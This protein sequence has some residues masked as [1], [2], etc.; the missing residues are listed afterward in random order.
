MITNLSY[1]QFCRKYYDDVKVWA[2]IAMAKYINMFGPLP[3]S[4]DTELV[5]DVCVVHALEKAF[6]KYDSTNESKASLKT[7]IS[8]ILQN[9]IKTEIGKEFTS[10]GS[11][12]RVSM[13]GDFKRSSDSKSDFTPDLDGR[14]VEDVSTEE[15]SDDT[16]SEDYDYCDNTPFEPIDEEYSEQDIL[17]SLI[18]RLSRE[19]QIILGCWLMDPKTYAD[20][21][22]EKLGWDLSRR[23]HVQKRKERAVEALIRMKEEPTS[24]EVQKDDTAE[25][26]EP[27]DNEPKQIHAYS[28]KLAE[29]KPYVEIIKEYFGLN[30]PYLDMELLLLNDDP[31]REFELVAYVPYDDIKKALLDASF[32]MGDDIEEYTCLL[33][34]VANLYYEDMY[35]RYEKA[36]MEEADDYLRWTCIKEDIVQLYRFISNHKTEE[37]IT[38]KIGSDSAELHNYFKW[39]QSLLDNHLFP[40]CIPDIKDVKQATQFL[41]KTKGRKIENKVATAIVNGLATYFKEKGLI[42]ARAPKNLCTFLRKFLVMMKLKDASD[43][44]FTESSIKNWIN[45]IQGQKEDP[46]IY[47]PEIRKI[48]I[49]ELKEIPLNERADRWL[50]NPE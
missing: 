40:N 37:P 25:D 7:Y 34:T 12:C 42:A 26:E 44:Y 10:T 2:N 29:M 45:N 31:D 20:V 23:S 33:W 24:Q 48:S 35:E 6:N 32:N 13:D 41:A 18:R 46:K 49:E 38:V 21:A 27:S 3:P 50:F 5:K 14:P 4:I 15:A 8:K 9:Q 36:A 30:H 47:T 1:E 43:S 28:L 17:T 22:L 19:D 11:K 39:F 16:N